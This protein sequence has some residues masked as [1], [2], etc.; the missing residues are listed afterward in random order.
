MVDCVA[1]ALALALALAKMEGGKKQEKLSY[2]IV[3]VARLEHEAQVVATRW[4]Y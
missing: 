2:R 3:A 4:Q 1:L